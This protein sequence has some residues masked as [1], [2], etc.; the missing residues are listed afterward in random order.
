M[1]IKFTINSLS[2]SDYTKIRQSAGFPHFDDILAE[3]IINGSYAII[4]MIYKKEIIG[5]VRII[6]DGVY[7]FYL[8]DFIINLKY[9][10]QGFGS[11]LLKYIYKYLSEQINHKSIFSI[12]LLASKNTETFYIKNGF[13]VQP[14]MNNGPGMKIYVREGKFS[15]HRNDLL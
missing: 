7:S 8:N 14:D 6:G 10:K 4:S 1:D 11:K 13:R 3:R 15:S 2:I 5:I 9:Q 12:S